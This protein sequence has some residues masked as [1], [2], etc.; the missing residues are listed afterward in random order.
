MNRLNAH[1]DS[2]P[3]VFALIALLA[4]LCLLVEPAWAGTG[5]GAFDT[6]WTTLKDWMQGTLGRVIA[7]AMILGGIARQSLISF[8]VGVGGGMGLYATPRIVE[9]IV[10]ATLPMGDPLWPLWMTLSNGLQYGKMHAENRRPRSGSLF[11]HGRLDGRLDF[12]R[13]ADVRMGETGC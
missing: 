13:G 5:G 11:K 1:A 2:N 7:G 3:R 9:G 8:A 10:S 12:K 6:V 4:V